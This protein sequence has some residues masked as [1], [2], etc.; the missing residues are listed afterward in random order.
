MILNIENDLNRFKDIVKGRLREDL[1]RYMGSGELL[2]RQGDEV[3]SI[4]LPQIQIP[5][6]RYGANEQGGVGQG[7]GEEGGEGSKAGD[8]EGPALEPSAQSFT[9]P[10]RPRRR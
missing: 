9:A 5:R 1:K 8:A 7:E 3:V 6:L 4:P 2:G 10:T